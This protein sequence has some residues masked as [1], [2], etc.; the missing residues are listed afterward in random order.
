MQLLRK[1]VTENSTTEFKFDLL[2]TKFLVKNLTSGDIYACL[3][4]TFVK[5]SSSRILTENSEY[6]EIHE[7]LEN[8]V[9]S[10]MIY[11]ES[12]GEVEVQVL[13]YTSLLTDILDNLK[14][15]A[16]GILGKDIRKAI[17][18]SIQIINSKMNRLETLLSN[19]IKNATSTSPSDAEIVAARGDYDTLNDRL[20]SIDSSIQTIENLNIEEKF[21]E[22][23][24]SLQENKIL[25]SEE[26]VS[27]TVTDSETTF[28]LPSNYSSSKSLVTVYSDNTQI[29]SFSIEEVA[30]VDCVVLEEAVSNCTIKII[31]KNYTD[32]IISLITQIVN[33]N[34][35]V[36]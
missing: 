15:I 33:N 29:T 23:D 35:S 25:E 19:L 18:D 3:G 21:E 4:D 32:D 5:D 1:T 11:S 9:S 2:G 10:I 34:A 7:D 24:E 12:A 17:H 30:Y 28:N 36:G 31:C 13:T 16:T 14:I 26:T 6:L 27:Y 22:I 20:N 8:P